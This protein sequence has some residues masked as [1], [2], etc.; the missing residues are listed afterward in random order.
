M[1]YHLQ[2]GSRF[3]VLRHQLLAMST[4][5]R[6]EFDYPNVVAIYY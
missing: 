1:T 6:I 5:W 2:S 3:V 4:P